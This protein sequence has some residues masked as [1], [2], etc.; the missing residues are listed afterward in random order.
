MC[1]FNILIRRGNNMIIFNNV[2]KKGIKDFSLY[3]KSGEMICI[4]DKD[5][6]KINLLFKLIKGE[7]R[8]ASGEIRFLHKGTYTAEIPDN[9]AAYVFKKNILL[10]KRTLEE[11]LEYIMRVKELDMKDCSSRIRRILDIVDL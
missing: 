6:K 2:T 4:N 10:A 3:I 1:N 7:E 8:P 11:N 9:M 5:S